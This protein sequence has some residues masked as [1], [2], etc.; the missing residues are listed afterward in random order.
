MK[1]FLC[2]AMITSLLLSGCFS[3][4]QQIKEPVTF[5][6]LRSQYQYGNS[7]SIMEREEREASGHRGDLR[8]LMML[9]LM[10][11]S[12]EELRSPLPLSTKILSAEQEGNTVTLTLSEVPSSMTD[13]SFS[14]AC[15]CL[16]KTCM[17]LTGADSVT[18]ISGTRSIT[19]GADNLI[20]T[21]SDEPAETEEETQ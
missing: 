2:L 11:P 20:L 13:A 3:Q 12:N 16:T 17:G 1:R 5:Y 4:G 7:Q 15:A 18:V 14:L 9:Y 19:M 21:D 8:Y 6:Y 10:G